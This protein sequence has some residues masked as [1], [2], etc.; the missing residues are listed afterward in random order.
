MMTKQKAVDTVRFVSD[1]L[2]DPEEI[3]SREG[4][5]VIHDALKP[6][7][8]TWTNECNGKRDILLTAAVGSVNYD[9][10]N[11]SSDLDLKAVYMPNFS[12]FYHG[13]F[14]KFNFV[15]DAFDCELAPAHKY[16]EYVLKGSLNHF[17]LLVSTASLARPDF[18]HIMHKYLVPMT[19][20][21]VIN[22]VKAAWFMG[23]KAHLDAVRSTWKP[24]KAANAL[25]IMT[26]L[27]TYLDEGRFEYVPTGAI[28]DAIMRL[29][30]KTMEELEYA[31]LFEEL[32]DTAKMMAYTMYQDQPRKYELS[33]QV[34]GMDQTHTPKWTEM[35]AELDKE[36][37]ALITT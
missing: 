26:F 6:A 37:M 20:M 27:I 32:H 12:D 2:T 15:T 24:K 17:E 8:K 33:K 22:M 13:Q 18:I 3:I 30:N 16:V 34:L 5:G 19:E 9:L 11:D 23:M 31:S 21:N 7:L 4:M 25:R 28:R 36:M 35:R 1:A 14:P 10:L 29:K